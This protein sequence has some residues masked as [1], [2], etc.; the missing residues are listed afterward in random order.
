MFGFC[1]VLYSGSMSP[2]NS[3]ELLKTMIHEQAPV[4]TRRSLGFLPGGDSIPLRA[5]QLIEVLG[6]GRGAW[7][8]RLLQGQRELR[9]AWA[10]A[11]R[12]DLF[13]MGIAQEGVALEQI[14]FLE[15]V[16]PEQGMD[17]LLQLLRSSLFGAVVFERELL[18]RQRQD[19]Q[20]R[21][22]QLVAEEAGS[23]MVLLSA[24]P[25]VS[26]GVNVRVEIDAGGGMRLDKIKVNQIKG[27]SFA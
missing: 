7:C 10:L 21:K 26:F 12:L 13:P 17:I 8:I 2:K 18:P 11:S 5:G 20:I 23:M 16:P 22:M 15:Q 19:A 14:L 6:E 1:S 27:G 3:L 4:R 25:T 24:R 9:A